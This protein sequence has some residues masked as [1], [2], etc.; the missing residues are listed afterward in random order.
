V[1][2]EIRPLRCSHARASDE[3]C[4]NPATHEVVGPFPELYCFDHALERVAQII[5]ERW[6]QFGLER[7][8]VWC[9]EAI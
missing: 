7:Y 5:N 8:I 4:E 2:E 1:P 6:D 9:E 3:P